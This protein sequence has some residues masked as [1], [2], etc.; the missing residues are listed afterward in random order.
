MR[1]TFIILCLCGYLLSGFVDTAPLLGYSGGS[2]PWTRLTYMLAHTSPVHLLL[3]LFAIY[4]ISTS[5]LSRWRGMSKTVLMTAA[6]VGAF[7]AT[8]GSEKTLPTIGASGVMYFLAGVLGVKLVIKQTYDRVL[9]VIMLFAV[10]ASLN[11]V[12]SVFTH[13]N[14]LVHGLA[15]IYGVTFAT[16]HYYIQVYEQKRQEKRNIPPAKQ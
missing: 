3:N 16:T 7:L 12:W 2:A 13:I 9:S 5:V 15:W 6:I 11:V 4:T 10:I 8:F 14:A 1:R